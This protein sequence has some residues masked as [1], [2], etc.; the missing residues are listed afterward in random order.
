[1]SSRGARSPPPGT[2]RILSWNCQ[3]LGNPW[4]VRGIHKLVREQALKVRFL[5]ETRLDKEGYK[6]NCKELPFQNKLIV[7][8]PESG[9]GGFGA[10]LEIGA[11]TGGG[12]LHRQPYLG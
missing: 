9:G 10:S 4:T 12:E 8:K 6:K 2:I 11:E 5:M 1:M 3:G 7:K